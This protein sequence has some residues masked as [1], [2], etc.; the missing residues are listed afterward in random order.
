MNLVYGGIDMKDELITF[1]V[2]AQ[3]KEKIKEYVKIENISI[4]KLFR[5]LVKNYNGMN[6]SM[7]KNMTMNPEVICNLLTDIQKLKQDNPDI[8]LG[9]LEGGIDRLWQWS[10]L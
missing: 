2:S 10:N 8:D 4:S 9:E 1:R 6:N 7:N 3:E 5:K